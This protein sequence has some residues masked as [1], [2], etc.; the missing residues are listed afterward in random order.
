[1]S[2]ATLLKKGVMEAPLGVLTC[3]FKCNTPRVLKAYNYTLRALKEGFTITHQRT[4]RGGL[5][6]HPKSVKRG[7]Q[8]HPRG[9]K[10]VLQLHPPT[11]HTHQ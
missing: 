2:V 6:L 7:L 5:Q 8:L 3:M 1:M 11:V 4:K 9:V 10:K